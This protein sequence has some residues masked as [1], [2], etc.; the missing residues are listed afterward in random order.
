MTMH[1]AAASLGEAGM[2]RRNE[3]AAEMSETW[4]PAMLALSEQE[5]AFV[6]GLYE[7]RAN[8]TQAA[9]NAGY[10]EGRSARTL[11]VFAHRMARDDRISAAIAEVGRGAL[12]GQTPKMV[13][14]MIM[15]AT[16][17]KSEETQRKA[18]SNLLDRAGLAAPTKVEIEHS[19]TRRPYSEV[20]QEL[21]HLARLNGIPPEEITRGLAPPGVVIDHE[22][23]KTSDIEYSELPP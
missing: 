21:I 3:I 7:P 11:Q 13:R 12:R 5:R 6:V 8:A 15:L 9:R 23:G 10:G 18:T 14:H 1:T 16:G 22:T 2:S 17:A 19:V 4:G 20:W